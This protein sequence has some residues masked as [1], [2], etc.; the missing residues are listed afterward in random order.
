M[1]ISEETYKNLDLDYIFD[2]L[3]VYTPY[4]KE[5]KRIIK[6]FEIDERDKLIE[7]L[8]KIEKITKLIEIQ[9]YDFIEIRNYFKHI[10]DLRMTLKRTKDQEVLS[11]TELYEIKL[12]INIIMKLNI[13]LNKLKW[14]IPKDIRIDQVPY[15][16]N[17]FDPQGTETNTFYIYDEYSESLS[18]I[19]K[20]I[21]KIEKDISLKKKEL[22]VETERD[23]NLKL[24]SNGEIIVNK[25]D[26]K[27]LNELKNYENLVYSMETYMNVTFRIKSTP[28]IDNLNFSLEELKSIEELEEY[29][30]RNYLSKEI[31]KYIEEI[32]GN[33]RAIAKLDLLIAKAYQSIGFN[34]IKPEIINEN[35]LFILEGRHLK[36]EN[37]LR[38]QEKSFTPITVDISKGV[39][40][41]TGANMGGKTVSLRI[42][43]MLA[44]M[45]QY[46]LFVP[47]KQMKLSLNN[48]IFLSMG[49]LQSLDKGLSTFGGEIIKV[50]EAIENADQEGIILIDELARGTNPK[51]GY[52]ISKALIN[53]LKDK[54]S[55]TVLTTHFDG[56]G[57]DPKIKHLQ[58]KGLSQE[59]FESIS[60]ELDPIE[61]KQGI[62]KLHQY[63]DYRL[64]E[65]DNNKQV[66]KDAINISRLMGLDEE[67]LSE[68]ER[69]LSEYS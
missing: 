31:E 4:G 20:K 3:T 33:I 47:A 18:S 15:L 61:K 38:K 5:L 43:G 55:I 6:P 26:D 39:T 14:E 44:A 46:G 8:D 10:K 2:N 63:M 21:R 29:N 56:L 34:C 7:E 45:A 60:K 22:Q 66:P 62:E 35:R 49:D 13:A 37:I 41:I 25:T 28:Q 48:H 59:T 27:K 51:E 58:V 24:R 50:K 36:I 52:A 53:Y 57:D 19:R 1:I 9:R 67:I 32:E 40:C 65:V 54:K 69:I 12:F 68:A 17:I 42:I 30:V 16:Q 11:N 64:Y 23:L